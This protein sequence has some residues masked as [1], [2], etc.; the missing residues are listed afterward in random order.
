MS[1]NILDTV[2][3]ID[4]YL[5]TLDFCHSYHLI[6]YHIYKCIGCCPYHSWA[7]SN[8]FTQK[9]SRFKSAKASCPYHSWVSINNY[10]I[11][12]FIHGYPAILLPRKCPVNWQKL[13]VH[14]TLG[15]PLRATHFRK[16]FPLSHLKTFLTMSINIL[17]TVQVIDGYRTTLQLFFS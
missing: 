15:Y 14:I 4:G 8:S 11:L 10:P 9:M 13:T 12:L 16:S 17:D 6:G 2:Q 1:I 5:T 3:I 7:S